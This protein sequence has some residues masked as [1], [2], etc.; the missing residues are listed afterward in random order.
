MLFRSQMAGNESLYF[1]NLDIVR[2][3][4]QKAKLPFIQIILSLPYG[5]Y[6]NPSE[7]DLRWQVYTSLA[8]GARGIMY[9]TYWTKPAWK[10]GNG[11]AI[12]GMDGKRDVKYEWIRRLNNR[13]KALGP[14]LIQIGS[15]GVYATTP[16]PPGTYGLT[17]EA[18]VKQVEG[19]PMLIGCF[20]GNK[21]EPYIWVVNRSFK[22]RITAKLTMADNVI[23]TSEISQESG[24]PLKPIALENKSLEVS[25]DSGEGRLFLLGQK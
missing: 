7:A 20:K 10:L 19:G 25:L 16:L 13:L 4:C 22:D 14:T 18:P 11:P 15:T 1:K 2:Q 3:Q 12:I 24:K 5:S 6:R 17:A 23:S 8:Y 21:E 9:F